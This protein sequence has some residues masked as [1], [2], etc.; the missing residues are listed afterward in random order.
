MSDHLGLTPSKIPV[1]DAGRNLDVANGVP[2]RPIDGCCGSPVL[3]LTSANFLYDGVWNQNS[4]GEAFDQIQSVDA[5][6]EDE[7]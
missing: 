1:L 5:G 3:P 2:R 7:G 6:E 4:G